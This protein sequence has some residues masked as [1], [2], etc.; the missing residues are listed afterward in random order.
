MLLLPVGT[1]AGVILSIPFLSRVTITDE[2][3][4]RRARWLAFRRFLR[5]QGSLGDV[6]A[7]GIAVWGRFL[8]YGAALGV[9]RAAAEALAPD[10]GAER[11]DVRADT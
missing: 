2:G 3:V 4:R 1:I 11:V 8:T 6:G 9:A 10:D 7:P 5:A